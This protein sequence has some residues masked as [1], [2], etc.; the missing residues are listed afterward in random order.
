[1]DIVQKID[2][3]DALAIDCAEDVIDIIYYETDAPIS[4][5]DN[6]VLYEKIKILTTEVIGE[7]LWDLLEKQQH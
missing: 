1:M 2:L 5:L 7:Y 3:V 4:R 6:K